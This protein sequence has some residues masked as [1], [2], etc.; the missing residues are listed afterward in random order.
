MMKRRVL[1]VVCTLMTMTGASAATRTWTGSAGTLWSNPGNWA[2]GAAPVA[3]DALVFPAGAANLT[4]QNDLAGEVRFSSMSFDDDYTVTGNAVGLLSGGLAVTA[5]ADVFLNLRINILTTQT[6][7]LRPPLT[8]IQIVWLSNPGQTLTLDATQ[9]VEMRLSGSSRIVHTG[10]GHRN[11]RGWIVGYW[12]GGTSHN[13]EVNDG[14]LT[15]RE[16]TTRTS[17]HGMTLNGDPCA[18]APCDDSITLRK[19]PAIWTLL[20]PLTAT[21]GMV[22]ISTADA[23][24]SVTYAGEVTLGPNVVFQAA[25]SPF[26]RWPSWSTGA[27]LSVGTPQVPGYGFSAVGN[28][29]VVLNGATLSLNATEPFAPCATQTLIANDGTDAVVGTFDGLPEGATYT[30]ASGQ[31][32]RISYAGGTGNDVTLTTPGFCAPVHSDHTGD[33][34]ADVLWRKPTTGEHE[35]WQLSGVSRESVQPVRQVA[36]TY[37]KIAGRGDFN[38]DGRSDILWRHE[39]SGENYL[40]LMN[41]NAIVQEGTVNVVS[42][43]SW[44]IAAV[45]DFDADAK[46]D[47]LWRNGTTGENYLYLMD[48]LTIREAWSL[49]SVPD[50]YWRIVAAG[51]L[52]GD[53]HADIVWRH[54]LTGLVY[55]WLMN[56]PVKVGANVIADVADLHWEV[57]AAGDFDADGKA[58]VFWRNETTGEYYLYLMDGLTVASRGYVVILDDLGWKVAAVADYSADGR[59]DILWR[60]DTTGETYLYLM[61]GFTIRERGFLP[62]PAA[63]WRAVP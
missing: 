32:F 58:D 1:S 42:D 53:G 54:A 56:G 46:A 28:R 45:A 15:F 18:A 14:R 10:G 17:G 2:E 62:Q 22:E 35:L 38:G 47:V 29:W 55:G 3:E 60:H 31:Q 37:W 8:R 44:K 49:D 26:T 39:F 13:Q 63:E 43:P 40:W 30:T 11:V 34:K 33:H 27:P 41:G 9:E 6:W 52:N 23:P 36:D 59:S 7:I 25:L 61:D 19:G 20:G 4:N 57:A 50:T 5:Q 48:G 21:G 12:E 51:D 16:E 24:N